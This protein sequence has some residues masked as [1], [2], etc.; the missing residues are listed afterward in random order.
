MGGKTEPA[1]ILSMMGSVLAEIREPL[2]KRRA[3]CGACGKSSSRQ[4]MALG[5]NPAYNRLG[6]YTPVKEAFEKSENDA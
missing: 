6:V 5:E 2:P 3:V 1:P 4:K